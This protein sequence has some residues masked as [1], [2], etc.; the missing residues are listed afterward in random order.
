MT[1]I[2][3]TLPRVVKGI[4]EA[5]MSSRLL[6]LPVVALLIVG[7]T[8]QGLWRSLGPVRREEVEVFAAQTGLEVTPRNGRLVLD[9]LARTRLWRVLGVSVALVAV[10]AATVVQVLR[11]G[12]LTVG[13]LTLLWVLVGHFLAAIC[14]ELLTA[15]RNAAGAVRT[16]SLRPRELTSY[17]GPW[18]LQWPPLLGIVGAVAALLA[19]V[20]GGPVLTNAAAGGGAF[21]A[22]LLTVW[23]TRYVLQ[24]PQPEQAPDL[25]A[26][27][28]AVRSRSVHVIAGTGV[29]I[30]LWLASLAVGG[31]LLELLTR[32]DRSLGEA[33]AVPVLLVTALVLPIVGFVWGRRLARRPFVM[34]APQVEALA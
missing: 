25:Q 1:Q 16:A 29:G 23:A 34:P 9:A 32:V 24:R 8:L 19:P 26:A 30:E 5:G 18:A 4:G 3:A 15:R 28:N 21:L 31:V 13:L 27:D 11:E 6:V 12:Q 14:A 20:V 10:V 22:W 33:L 2:I 17:V 7:L